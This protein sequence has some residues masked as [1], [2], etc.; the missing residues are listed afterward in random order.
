MEAH[1]TILG[2][3]SALPA[4]GRHPS[5]QVLQFHKESCL[6][7]C[8]EGT[9][10]QLSEF[11]VKRSK[12]SSIFISH[13]HGDHIFGLPGLITSYNH[14]ARKTPLTIYGPEGLKKYVEY[15]VFITGNPLGFDL[16]IKEFNAD[17][18][19]VLIDNE[20]LTIKT[21]PL[22]HRI[23]T[24]GYLF[25]IKNPNLKIK[26]GVF[27]EYKVPKEQRRLI[28]EG[29]DFIAEDG[30]HIPNDVFT[31]KP[32][33]PLTYAYLSD[34]AYL[35]SLVSEIKGYNTIYH[36]ATFLSDLADKAEQT[37]HSTALQAAQIALAAGVKRL[38]IGH[39]SSRYQDLQP[40]LDEAQHIFA[41]TYLAVEGKQFTMRTSDN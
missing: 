29:A 40:F 2:A 33:Q 34:T 30:S 27:D 19:H 13:L 8:G 22:A 36:E 26:P 9:Q 41:R 39:F 14:Y 4:Q 7:D 31:Q 23:P 21:I 15:S 1:L 16:T 35:P 38:I 37:R 25:Q 20:W 3:N 17:I 32:I 12:I 11:G 5:A 24:A 10:L 28:Q 18:P 6:I